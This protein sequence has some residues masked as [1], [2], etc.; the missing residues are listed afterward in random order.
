MF[1]WTAV[2]LAD[3]RAGEAAKDAGAQP[4]QGIEQG[5]DVD[6]MGG[7]VFDDP[8]NSSTG[9]ADFSVVKIHRAKPSRRY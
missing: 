3:E 7:W 1:D 9:M 4:M 2:K 5:Q 6:D 8:V